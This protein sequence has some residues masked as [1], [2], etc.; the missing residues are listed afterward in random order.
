[1]KAP[2]DVA[3]R[4]AIV[5][6]V[7]ALTPQNRRAW[8]MMDIKRLLCHTADQWRM[9]IGDIT[10]STPSGSL[11]HAPRRYLLIHVLPWPKGSQGPR[12]AFTTS[13]ESWE[14]DRAAVLELI[15][16]FGST[17]SDLLA[18]THPFFGRMTERDWGVLSH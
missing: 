13:P 8:G 6:R 18:P 3:A 14:E 5:G 7:E 9:A 4:S 11:R 15:E 17:S 1:M 12:E 2:R 16:R 10:T